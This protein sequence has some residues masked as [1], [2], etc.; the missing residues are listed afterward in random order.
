MIST[1]VVGLSWRFLLGEDFGVINYLLTAMGKSPVKWLTNPKFAMGVVIFVTAWSL[2]G[3]YMVM[4]IAGIE[5][6]S[7]TYYEAAS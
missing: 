4:F 2:A 1:I 5:S 7:D 3:Y 6:I